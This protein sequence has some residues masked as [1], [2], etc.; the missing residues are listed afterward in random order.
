MRATSTHPVIGAG[1]DAQEERS[2]GPYDAVPRLGGCSPEEGGWFESITT[3]LRTVTSRPGEADGGALKTLLGSLLVEDWTEAQADAAIT[4]I[5]ERVAALA[6][7]SDEAARVAE[8][9][10]IVQ[11]IYEVG[12]H[13]QWS[14]IGL[15][16]DEQ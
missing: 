4:E 5:G 2:K 6:T 3:T 12:A 7:I 13:C 16:Q 9:G 8:G 11:M 1:N 15:A 14:G 10:R